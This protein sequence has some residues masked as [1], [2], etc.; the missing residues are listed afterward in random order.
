[1]RWTFVVIGLFFTLGG[2][3]VRAQAPPIGPRIEITISDELVLRPGG[4]RTAVRDSSG[5]LITRPGDVIQYT[6]IAVNNGTGPAHEVELVDPIPAGT[7]YAL[8][9]A[10]GEGMAVSYSIDEGHLY[11]F[12]PVVYD[13]RLPDGTFEKRPAPAG[14]Y[15]HVKWLVTQHI[16]PGGSVTASLRVRVTA[17]QA[18]AK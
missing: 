13:F 17:G 10:V 15:T 3:A 1:M 8:D 14:M 12:P 6:L 16:P 7:E 9:S 18:Q 11:Q 2:A 4:T 5:N